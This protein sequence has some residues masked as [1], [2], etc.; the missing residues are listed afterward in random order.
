LLAGACADDRD[1]VLALRGNP[2]R[3]DHRHGG[4]DLVG[5]LGERVGEREFASRFTPWKRGTSCRKSPSV[6][7]RSRRRPDSSPR[8]RTPQAVMLTPSSRAVE[9]ISSSMPR[10]RS[11]YSICTSLIRCT[12]AA[13][14][15]VPAPTSESARGR[16]TRP[17]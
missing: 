10:E 7:L 14:R 17:G 6:G 5:D 9:R 16:C 4:A 13:S 1:D 11:E 8:E 3:R 2:R 15:S 12:A